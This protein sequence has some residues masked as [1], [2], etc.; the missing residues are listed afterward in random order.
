MRTLSVLRDFSGILTHSLNAEGMLRQFLLLLRE[1]LSINRGVIFLHQPYAAGSGSTSGTEQR[2][3]R[4][5][6]AIGLPAA[7]LQHFE[8]SFESGIGGHLLRLGRIL[9]RNSEEVRQDIEAQKEF[10][11]LGAQVAVPILDRET[12]I[13]VAVFDGRIT[14]EPLVNSEL[15]L[16]FHL[17]EQLGLAIRNIWL[18]DQLAGN[19]EMMADILRELSSACIVVNR[20]LAILHANKSARRIFTGKLERRSGEFE[21]SD[22]PAVLGSKIYQVLKTGSAVASFR[23]EPED[24]SGSIY[25]IGVVPFQ[26]QPGG[27]PNSALL[28]AEDLTQSEQLQRL[29]IEAAN[30]RLVKSMA[31]RLANEIGNALVPLD[32]HRQLLPEKWK[33]SEFRASLENAMADSVKRVSRLLSQM[34]FLARDGLLS[35][36]SFPLGPLIEEAYQEA[37]RYEPARP[38]QLKCEPSGKG[39]V[40]TGDRMALKHALAE[41]MLNALQANPSDPKV[42]VRLSPDTKSG[43]KQGLEIEVQD[44]GNGFPPEALD[45]VTEPFFTMRNVGVGLGLTVSRKIIETHR[46]KLEIKPGKPGVVR[47]SLPL[48]RPALLKPAV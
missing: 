23:Y 10:E 31:Y 7:L 13:G 35:E 1:I 27:L 19:H 3:L 28:T 17:L 5:V 16:V 40:A 12:A 2:R 29:E 33:D 32:A 6:S 47:I 46:G 48:E 30:L 15:E 39:L 18:H 21:F 36:E 9:R 44:N 14:G 22:L 37:C 25:N 38:S 41:V 20:D 45:K 42:G 8:L 24:A 34:R 43:E 11:L 4:A 26:R